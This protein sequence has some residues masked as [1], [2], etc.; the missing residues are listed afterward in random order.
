M[1]FID[2]NVT[3][4]LVFAFLFWVY[5]AF[6][7]NEM[8]N[9]NFPMQKYRLNA[10]AVFPDDTNRFQRVTDD[11]YC[12]IV[13][14]KRSRQR[15][16]PIVGYENISHAY[17]SS[18]AISITDFCPLTGSV[19]YVYVNDSTDSCLEVGVRCY[20]DCPT[21]IVDENTTSIPEQCLSVCEGY[22]I[23]NDSV[24]T[25]IYEIPQVVNVAKLSKSGHRYSMSSLTLTMD[26]CGVFILC[27]AKNKESL[28]AFY[29][30]TN[31]VCLIRFS[32][33]K[34]R[35]IHEKRR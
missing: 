5:P 24:L 22:R 23:G 26:E 29:G 28:Y 32:P 34:L 4:Y 25:T 20:S 19:Q 30:N 16:L 11:L 33:V 9:T 12:Q 15:I 18:F 31:D 27:V 6:G 7:Q 3:V 17:F 2:K 8:R 10:S 21:I 35:S 14:V 13:I 1:E